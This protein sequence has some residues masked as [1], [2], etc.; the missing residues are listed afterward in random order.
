[1]N[2]PLKR[3]LASVITMA[4]SFALTSTIAKA[5]DFA[6]QAG[7]AIQKPHAPVEA[8]HCNTG[9]N[10][11]GVGVTFV[12]RSRHAL[13]HASMELKY[14]D[15]E[16]VLIGRIQREYDINPPVE[17]GEQGIFQDYF[18]YENLAEPASSIGKFTCTIIAARFSGL[19]SWSV[20]K[21]W[22]EPL[23]SGSDDQSFSQ[24]QSSSGQSSSNDDSGNTP[25][26]ALDSAG[27]SQSA[28]PAITLSVSNAW[29]DTVQGSVYVHTALDIHGGASDATLTP[30][31]L[32]LSMKLANGGKRNY[33]ASAQAAPTYQKISALSNT[34]ITANEVDPKEDLGALGSLIIPAHGTVHIV[35]TFFVGSDILADPNANRQVTLR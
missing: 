26:S 8:F 5:D 17:S 28:R 23:V 3:T 6:H 22:N 24:G 2:S 33:G 10:W 30:D 25:D 31:M 19:K 9:N 13:I 27:A 20:D 12:N 4:V 16:G 11:A 32:M 18:P 7:V 29:N 21:R 35:A 34:P 15:T 1:M 14:Y